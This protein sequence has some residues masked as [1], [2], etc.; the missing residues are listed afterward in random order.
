MSIKRKVIVII[1]VCMASGRFPGQPLAKVLALPI[2]EHVRRRVVISRMVDDVYVATADAAIKDVVANHGGKVIITEQSPRPTERLARAAVQLGLAEDDIII[3]IW[4]HEPL[5]VPELL[6]ELI[7]PML[8]YT[9]IQC[10]NLLAMISDEKQMHDKD[11][12]KAVV[13]LNSRIMCFSR[14]P[15]PY[16]RVKNYSTAYR[17]TGFAAFTASFLHKISA[18]TPSPLEITEGIDFLRILEN[19]CPIRGVVYNRK[20]ISVHQKEDIAELEEALRKDYDQS[21]LYQAILNM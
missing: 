13:D 14:S 9:D 21:R 3:S 19:G 18:F 16:R 1:P 12:V 10:T 2:I 5:F 8:Q 15:L 17:Q 4:G 7:A 6:Q 11:T 20:L